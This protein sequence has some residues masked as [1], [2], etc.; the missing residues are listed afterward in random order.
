MKLPYLLLLLCGMQLQACASPG[1]DKSRTASVLTEDS[2]ATPPLQ[3]SGLRLGAGRQELYFPQLKGK[4][5]G[6]LIN[7]TSLLPEDDYSTHLLDYLLANDIQVTTIFTPEHGF[8]G[9]ADAGEKV[10]SGTDAQTG[11]PIVS[12]YG[13]NKKPSAEQLKNV[14][15]LV[16]DIQ[17][18]G[19]R[20]Y[21]YISSMHY[22]MEACA[23]NGKE[24]IVLDR[25]N[26][27]GHY[28]DG[29]MLDPAFKSFVGMHPIPVVHGLTVGE[30]AQMINEEGW[31]AGGQKCRLRVVPMENY[32]HATPYELPVK[33]SPNLPNQQSIL[34]YPSLC[35]FEGT[36][37]SVGRGTPFPF[38]VVGYPDE[39]FGDFTFTPVSTPGAAKNPVHENKTCYGVDLRDAPAPDQLNLTYLI[40]FYH[41]YPQKDTFFVKFFNTLAGT[42]QLKKQIVAG[43]TEA[44]I[45]RSWQPSLQEYAKLREKYLLYPLK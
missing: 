32:T 17:D 26:P 44:E 20:F 30:L 33:P 10:D 38:Q 8:R 12:L 35:F 31:L 22:A 3:A 29:P 9:T 2:I 34:L 27:H 40:D 5:V 36:P 24:F 21:T 45:R 37:M 7:H 42:D 14:D 1:K 6:L 28:I 4:R 16:F 43:A 18:V 15:V 39:R 23:E 13:N 11:L 41:K 19:A 25:P